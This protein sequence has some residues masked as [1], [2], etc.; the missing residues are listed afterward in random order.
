M[1]EGDRARRLP[2]LAW[3]GPLP[4]ERA[5]DLRSTACGPSPRLRRR[6][7]HVRRLQ[8]KER[9]P[10]NGLEPVTPSLPFRRKRL[11]RV[12]IESQNPLNAAA[13]GLSGCG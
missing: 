10:S 7:R 11:R 6:T 1:P 2:P 4:D 3:D 9:K 12:C 13:L 5:G 8:G